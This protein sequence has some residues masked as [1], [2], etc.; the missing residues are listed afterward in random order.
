MSMKIPMTSSGNEPAT[1]RLVA[2]CIN[3]MRYRVP[4][5][6][7]L[8]SRIRLQQMDHDTGPLLNFWPATTLVELPE[9]SALCE[10]GVRSGYLLLCIRPSYKLCQWL[11]S[12]HRLGNFTRQ[13]VTNGIYMVKRD[14][15]E[16]AL[17][18]ETDTR[19]ENLRSFYSIHN[20]RPPVRL[21][22]NVTSHCRTYFLKIRVNL[23]F[24]S[25]MLARIFIWF[26]TWGEIFRRA[27]AYIPSLG[28]TQS[29]VQ[30]LLRADSPGVK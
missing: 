10:R 29:S 20:S 18:L 16:E 23:N 8:A 24:V 1:F 4:P 26:L 28:S 22:N 21:L 3:Q 12:S 2:Q 11:A 13:I 15:T 30:E 7:L 17:Y 14:F 25:T 27:T 5:I 6:D 9:G 19:S